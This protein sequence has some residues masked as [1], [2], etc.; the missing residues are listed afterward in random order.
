[1]KI[2]TII[3]SI[4]LAIALVIVIIFWR[5]ANSENKK[6]TQQLAQAR[7]QI[8]SLE[9]Q[10][11]DGAKK[12]AS[13]AED[14]K[15]SAAIVA[16]DQEN[17]KGKDREISSLKSTNENLKADQ[18]SL[19]AEQA[20]LKTE[21]QKATAAQKEAQVATG[22]ASAYRERLAKT[23]AENVVLT[24]E[25]DRVKAELEQAK[26]TINLL[27]LKS[28]EVTMSLGFLGRPVFEPEMLPPLETEFY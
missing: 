13:L 2:I 28:S 7:E 4:A 19:R 27:D 12:A 25:R 5:G 15:K 14:L 22:E 20:R 26:K 9:S 11:A 23:E 8:S 18:A 6:L 16:Q 17:L 10:A 1:V 3:A 21:A 24:Q